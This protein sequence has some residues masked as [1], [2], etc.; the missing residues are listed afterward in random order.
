MQLRPSHSHWKVF[1]C[2]YYMMIL[3][4]IFCSNHDKSSDD[5]HE[6]FGSG[7]RSRHQQYLGTK[8]VELWSCQEGCDYHDHVMTMIMIM[9]DGSQRESQRE[10]KRA[11]ES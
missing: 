3:L 10:P 5:E 4:L 7:E 2:H 6:D 9:R 11:R 1:A 8:A